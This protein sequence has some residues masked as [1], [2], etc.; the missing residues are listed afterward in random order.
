MPPKASKINTTESHF[1]VSCKPLHQY[2]TEKSCVI[3]S[4]AGPIIATA[5]SKPV[6]FGSTHNPL[7][8]KNYSLADGNADSAILYITL[9]P[10]DTS[11]GQTLIKK[12]PD[13]VLENILSKDD[14]ASITVCWLD[15]KNHKEIITT[16]TGSNAD[17]REA[18][19]I[20]NEDIV[21]IRL[22]VAS[23]V[24]RH[25]MNTYAAS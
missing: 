8:S 12:V 2:I 6:S 13:M 11:E 22:T 1:K 17:L 7:A 5:A 3:E 9:L 19:L 14:E 20:L 4:V 16:F 24:A 23:D 15:P 25:E 18:K 21:K 10:C